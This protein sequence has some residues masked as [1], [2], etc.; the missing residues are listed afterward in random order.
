MLKEYNIEKKIYPID[1]ITQS[2]KDFSE[3]ATIDYNDW[4]LKISW[5]NEKEI[6]EVFNEFANYCI[7]LIDEE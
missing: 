4:V 3:V 2:I 6:E 5:E 1:I 7:W